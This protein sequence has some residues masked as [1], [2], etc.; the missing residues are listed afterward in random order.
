MRE[1]LGSSLQQLLL[2][3]LY[4][5][6]LCSVHISAV[7]GF[8]Q[9]VQESWDMARVKSEYG[10]ALKTQPPANSH[11]CKEHRRSPKVT[12]NFLLESAENNLEKLPYARRSY[13]A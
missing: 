5:A 2:S 3:L 9:I 4:I 6:E 1:T 11:C 7:R 8:R 10:C 13:F 12:N